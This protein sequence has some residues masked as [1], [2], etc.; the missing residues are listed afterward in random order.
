MSHPCHIFQVGKKWVQIP[1]P[2]A[3]NFEKKL[4]L[5]IQWNDYHSFIFSWSWQS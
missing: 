5:C 3:L 4:Y 1:Q 2:K